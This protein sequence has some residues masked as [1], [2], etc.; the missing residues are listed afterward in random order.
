MESTMIEVRDLVKTYGQTRALKGISLAVPR[1]QIVGFLGPNGAGKTTTM[2]IVTGYLRPT[3]GDALIQGRPVSEDSMFTRT[4]IGYLPENAPLY[5]EMMVLEFLEFIAYLRG[6][7]KSV[8]G[9]RIKAMVD[10]CGLGD[11]LGKDI[12][13][14]SK[15]F[16]QRVGLAQ[17]MIHNPEILILDEPTSGLDPNQIADIRNLIRDLGREKTVVLSTHILPE[18]Q[19]TCNRVVIINDGALVADDT[20][21]GLTTGDG[22]RVKLLVAG[23]T[24]EAPDRRVISEVFSRPESVTRVSVDRTDDELT[25][26]VTVLTAPGADARRDL[27]ETAVTNDLILLEMQQDTVSLEETFRRLTARTGGGHA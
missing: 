4:R 26:A 10:S 12:G 5:E 1:G 21:E 23:R 24:E 9:P 25:M 16:R 27:F 3:A 15:G 19:A 7:E 11:V 8:Q 20:V 18:V 14:L 13:Q 22:G 6:V 17:A 2:K